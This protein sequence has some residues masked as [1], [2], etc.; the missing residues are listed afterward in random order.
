MPLPCCCWTAN[1]NCLILQPAEDFGHVPE[2]YKLRLG[3]GISGKRPWKGIVQGIRICLNP[4]RGWH[5]C[6]CCR[7]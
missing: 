1:F 3:E 4:T 6:P 2:S 7:K 5:T